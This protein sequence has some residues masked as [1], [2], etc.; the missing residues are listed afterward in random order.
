MKISELFPSRYLKAAD[1]DG[2][3]VFTAESLNQEELGDDTKPVLYFEEMEKGLVLNRTN[4][5]TTASLYGQDTE[6]GKDTEDWVGKRITLFATE[7]DFRGQQTLAI[8]VRMLPP[9]KR[10]RKVTGADSQ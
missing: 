5:N 9:K 1:L 4:A 6:Y 2:D 3:E 10:K 7:V 8:R